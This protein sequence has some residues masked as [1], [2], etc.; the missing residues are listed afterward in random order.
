MDPT[1]KKCLKAIKQ[2]AVLT[3]R[4]AA[5]PLCVNGEGTSEPYRSG[6]SAFRRPSAGPTLLMFNRSDA[7]ASLVTLEDNFFKK[8]KVLAFGFPKKSS[9]A[10][11]VSDNV[12]PELR[13]SFQRTRHHWGA[14]VS[15]QTN[16][17][18]SKAAGESQ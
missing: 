14:V 7:H 9:T 13:L 2:T 4:F 12:A 10:P 8:K 1:G 15:C 6:R 11:R 16:H 17:N 5:D 18:Q 3:I